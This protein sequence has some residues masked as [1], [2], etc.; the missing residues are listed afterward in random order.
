MFYEFKDSADLPIV[1]ERGDVATVD[2]GN[3]KRHYVWRLGAW[4]HE[5]DYVCPVKAD[6][7]DNEPNV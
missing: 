2:D 5:K 4:R 6:D 1:G 7:S 3:Y